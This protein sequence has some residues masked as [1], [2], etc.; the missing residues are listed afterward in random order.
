MSDNALRM[1]IGASIALNGI[2]EKILYVGNEERN[3]PFSTKYKLRRNKNLLE[4]DFI[5]FEEKREG[6]IKQLG[7]KDEEG[8]VIKVTEENMKVFSEELQKIRQMEVSH[9]FLKFKPEEIEGIAVP[10]FSLDEISLFMLAFIDD[11]SMMEDMK[12]QIKEDKND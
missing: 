10:D 3:L 9:E 5:F 2:I 11:P 6:L 7:E 1:T 4:K 8:N 12:T